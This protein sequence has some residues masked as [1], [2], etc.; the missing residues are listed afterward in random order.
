MAKI[1][2]PKSL[3]NLLEDSPLQALI[4]A[5]TDRAGEILADNKLPFFPDYT[6]HGTDHINQVLISEVDL[7]PKEVW[8]NSTKD[9][10]PRLLNA[11]DA[12]VLIGATLL[13]DIAMHLRHDGFLELVDESTRFQPLPWF[14]NEQEG[15][16][17]DRPWREL[18]LDFQQEARR[19]SDRKLGNI[20][21]LESVRLG[22]KF[23]NL[24]EN[25]GHWERNHFLIIGEFIR[26]HHARLAH[27][28]AIY[29]FPGLEVGPD[30]GQFPALGIQGNSL[31]RWA[32]LIG[33][34]ARSHGLSLR[35][36]QTYLNASPLHAHTPK[37]MGCAVFY[38][39]ALLRVADYLQIDRQRTPTALLKLRNPQSP[40]SVQEWRKH[41]AV[42][43]ISA[44]SNPRGKMVTVNP[45]I[46][47][48]V[49]LQLADLL[50]GLQAEMDHATAVLDEAY[51]RY[52]ELGLHQ[53]NLATRRVYSNLHSPAFL[54]SLPYVPERTGFAVDPNLLTLLVE[55][56]YG[57]EPGVG[58]RELMQNAVD[59]VC[60]LHAWCET[61]GIAIE[62]L[63]LPEQDSDVQIDF[64]QRGD[65]TWY[66][67][68]TDKGIGMTSE[69]IQNYFLRAGA[70]FRQSPDWAKEFLDEQGKPRVLRAGRFGI[71]AFAVFLLGSSFCLKTRHAGAT[72]T[73]C[74]AVEASADSQLIEIKRVEGLPVGTTIEVDLCTE[75]VATLGL[76]IKNISEH[77]YSVKLGKS[78]TD[79][80]CWDWPIVKR[81]IIRA[82]ITDVLTQKHVAP[83]RKSTP[84]PEWSFIHPK[85]FDAV[86]WTFAQY[87]SLMCNGI[88]ITIP[89]SQRR[90]FDYGEN[91]NF[92]WPT[93]TQI[94]RPNIAVLDSQANLL[95]T[96]QR[97]ALSDKNLPFLPELS[98]DVTLSFIAHALVCG[99]TSRTETLL[100]EKKIKP[101]PLVMYRDGSEEAFFNSLLRWCASSQAVIPADPWLYGLLQTDYCFVFGEI[102]FIY[103]PK[104]GWQ[105][106]I[107]S[108]ISHEKQSIMMWNGEIRVD[109]W[110]D[111]ISL[112]RRL[113][114]FFPELA[115]NGLQILDQ[116]VTD[117][118][119]LVS[120]QLNSE[121][122]DEITGVFEEFYY[123]E[124]EY[125]NITP[126]KAKREYFFFESK[127]STG[128]L[129]LERFIEGMELDNATKRLGDILFVAEIKTKANNPEPETLIAKLWNECLG[130]YPIPFDPMARCEL[131]EK[132]RQH[133]ELKRHIEAWE[134]MKRTGSKWVVSGGVGD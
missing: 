103:P 58:V 109:N 3:K 90:L 15:Y 6:D 114:D 52:T 57:K 92:N 12:V 18:W 21:G 81:R 89:E 127:N 67:R 25:T 71:G 98:R 106:F 4:R 77:A 23:E 72:K 75:S 94:A 45:D 79:W 37:P 123:Q 46:S 9:S 82:T 70:S 121:L 22:W 11:E 111:Q 24:P 97:Y 20:I 133:P 50:D 125:Q 132:G 2:F 63:D 32:D 48:A 113:G 51:G 108:N 88:K 120:F 28:I 84:S 41:L 26:R 99:P 131:I 44:A 31:Q 83:L 5:Y 105:D 126:K 16:A 73:K 87:P 112:V 129:P 40:V 17:A 68:V 14:K 62:S 33:L 1:E 36:C 118:Q 39:M 60:E 95:V 91:R 66:L 102:S 27:E 74:Y 96:T 110:E 35:V 100:S 80:F 55:P 56:L 116:N 54:D 8:A 124:A 42:Q 86:F 119:V 43:S 13:H 10:D 78:I 47:Q 134:E 128:V 29:G 117:M 85:D 107:I 19:F 64:I 49:Y 7:V 59:G 38:P 130:P 104:D 76:N 101:Y 65:G 61:H 115:E 93:D 53:L 34:A 69:T 122:S 30:E